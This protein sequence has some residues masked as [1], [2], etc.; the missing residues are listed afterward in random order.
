[1]SPR[2]P[3][4]L[5]LAFAAAVLLAVMALQGTDLWW[6]R[7]ADL[8]AAEARAARISA[9]AAEYVRGIF[10][11]SDTSL[12]QLVIHGRR[13]GGPQAPEADWQP[14]LEAAQASLHGGGSVSVTGADGSVRH[15]TLRAIVGQSRKHHYAFQRLAANDADVMVVDA[16]FESPVYRGRYVLPIA[17]RLTT[18]DGAFDGVVVAVVTLEAFRDFFKTLAVGREGSVTLFHPT[19]VLLFREP[20]EKDALGEQGKDHP[21]FRATQHAAAGIVKGPLVP[22]GPSSISGYRPVATAPIT[23]SVSLS[24]RE[25]LASWRDELRTALIELGAFTAA[26]GVLVLLV[27]RQMDARR[28]VERAFADLQAAEARRLR[29]ANDRLAA[30][31]ERER[32]ARSESQHASRLKDEFLMTLSHEM[33]TPLNA[34]LGWARMLTTGAVSTD[35][36]RQALHVIERNAQAQA[37]LVED[38]LDVSRAISGKLQIEPAI[39][40]L[41][42][43]VL[44]AVETL[45]P[46]M[47]ARRLHFETAVAPDVE[48][49]LADPDRLQQI[50]WNLLSNA[51]KFTPSQ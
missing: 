42:D 50:V 20:S 8:Q 2:R 22:G 29:E 21:V 47:A 40:N 31:L 13:V 10:D 7:A 28:L 4:S 46:A 15:S 44:A 49:I 12:R 51:I 30:A 25:A 37:R 18:S 9:V 35:G 16:P 34:I 23:V 24:E 33:R 36:H 27:F 41:P 6:R 39:V 19:G 32:A 1:M 11:V 45:R 26:L 43:T 17:R 5:V 14:I 38:L 48:P 3:K